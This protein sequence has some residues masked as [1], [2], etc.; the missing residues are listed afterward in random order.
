MLSAEDECLP[1]SNPIVIENRILTAYIKDIESEMIRT[2][3]DS[4]EQNM[5]QIASA[6]Y[7][8]E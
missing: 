3:F 4:V 5:P 1:Y 6:K 8:T 2:L 7:Y